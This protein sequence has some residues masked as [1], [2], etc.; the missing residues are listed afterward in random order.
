MQEGKL[1]PDDMCLNLSLG[2]NTSMRGD[3]AWEGQY[4]G[5]GSVDIQT[6]FT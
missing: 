1:K 3:R 2:T 6:S 4:W 5:C